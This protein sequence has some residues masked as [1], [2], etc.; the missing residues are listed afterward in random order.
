MKLY[1]WFKALKLNIAANDSTYF[2]SSADDLRDL[3]SLGKEMQALDSCISGIKY[4]KE[5]EFEK[6]KEC[7][8]FAIE[9]G[10]KKATIYKYRGLC[11]QQDNLDFD[12]IE[13][14]NQSIQIDPDDCETYYFRMNSLGKLKKYK[15][16]LFDLNKVINLLQ[17]QNSLNADESKILS[18]CKNDLKQTTKLSE[19]EKQWNNLQMEWENKLKE[20]REQAEKRMIAKNKNTDS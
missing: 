15:E 18:S 4:L 3:N 8:D 19:I 1:D 10:V 20:V 13:D 7:F 14:F 5:S 6:A 9:N 16:K 2:S 12:A 11:Y 17:Q